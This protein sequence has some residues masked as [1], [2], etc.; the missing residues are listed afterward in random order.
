M[1]IIELES[2]LSSMA[3]KAKI[4]RKSQNDGINHLE[5]LRDYFEDP[6]YKKLLFK[7]FA[8]SLSDADRVQSITMKTSDPPFIYKQCILLADKSSGSSVK[9]ELE[10]NGPAAT[11]H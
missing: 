8:Q 4:V 9:I 1:I 3:N 2:M 5:D 11:G 10:K 7:T 6:S